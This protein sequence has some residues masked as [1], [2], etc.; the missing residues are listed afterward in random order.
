MRDTLHYLT[1]GTA[2]P[3]IP[4]MDQTLIQALNAW[5]SAQPQAIEPNDA[6]LTLLRQALTQQGFL[7]GA[8][9]APKAE[10]GE[11]DALASAFTNILRGSQA[12]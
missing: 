7:A 2:F 3:L 10:G 5:R 4:G 8:P 9:A 6:I 12:G 1:S 11:I